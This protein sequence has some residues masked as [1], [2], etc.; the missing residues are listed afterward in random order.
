MSTA[1]ASGSRRFALLLPVLALLL[2]ALPSTAGASTTQFCLG[3]VTP[4]KVTSERDTGASYQFSCHD[5][6]TSFALVTSSELSSFDVTADVFDS[7]ATGGGL[8]GDDR[9][10]E[11]EGELPGN[12]FLCNG[13][14]AAQNRVIKASFD[15]TDNPCARDAGGDPLLKASVVVKT[16]DGKLNGP[17][18]LGKTIKG[19]AK[20][21][22]RSKS[23]RHKKSRT[24]A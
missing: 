24:H 18:R 7:S 22:K 20:P 1:H 6:I 13:T 16:G 5:A 9:F 19:C 4:I 10:G 14:Y 2:L 17:Y 15:T 8:R 3:T 21:A 12:G 11:C 23:G